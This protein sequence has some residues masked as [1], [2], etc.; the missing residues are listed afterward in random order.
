[1]TR[2]SRRYFT[3]PPGRVQ[4]YGHCSK[5]DYPFREDYQLD[6]AKDFSDP[7]KIKPRGFALG[8]AAIAVLRLIVAERIDD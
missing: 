3:N 4:L 6:L 2:A 7:G 5:P 1:M 8:T